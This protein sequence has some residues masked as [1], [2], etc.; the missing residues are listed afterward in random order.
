MEAS[1][2]KVSILILDDHKL[3]RDTWNF[4]LDLDPRFTVVANCG[5]GEEALKLA[6]QLQPQVILLDLVMANMSGFEFISR[7]NKIDV[8]SK[9]IILSSLDNPDDVVLILKLGAWGYV[10]KTI[11]PE[12]MF[13][14]IIR[15]NNGKKHLSNEIKQRLIA[16]YSENDAENVLVSLQEFGLDDVKNG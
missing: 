16:A 12:Q 7:L 11:R 6:Q 3:I 2:N 4:I 9:V 5:N 10:T 14:V 13:E 8:N 1:L 15:V